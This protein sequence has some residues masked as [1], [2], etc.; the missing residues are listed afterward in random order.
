MPQV[1]IPSDYAFAAQAQAQSARKPLEDRPKAKI[2]KVGVL[3]PGTSKAPK[4]KAAPASRQTRERLKKAAWPKAGKATTEVAATGK[5]AVTIGGLGMALAQE[6]AVAAAKS[7]KTKKKAKATGPAEEVALSV[8]SQS[9][10]KKAGVNGVL[11]T[12]APARTTSGD[13]DSLRVSLGYSSFND[14]YGGNFGPRLH[15]VSL[16]ACALTTPQKKSCR[17]QTPV[18]GADNDA[19]SQ[20]LTGT[21]PARTLTAGTPMLLAAAADS[22][23]GG[24]DY[25]ATSLSPTATWEAGGSTGDFTW[26]Y[27]LRVPPA[28]AGPAPNLSISYNSASVDGRTAGENNQTSVVGEGFSITES[29]IERKYGSC[30]DD[31]Q[32]GKGDLC[33]KYGNA[34]LVLNGKAV[35]GLGQVRMGVGM[36]WWQVG[37][38]PVQVARSVCSS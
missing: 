37:Q 26:N 9:A 27:P 18:A 21:L 3:K 16:P 31:G 5:A 25:S 8:H 30:K 6:P 28:T 24:G 1:V 13:S 32:S 34:T 10:A 4:D 7:A 20:T 33:W 19:E 2:N 15:L 23:G 12:V 14:V 11:L 36:S 17:T 35:V 38:A 22:S 29:Y